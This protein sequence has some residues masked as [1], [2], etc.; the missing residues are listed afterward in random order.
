MGRPNEAITRVEQGLQVDPLSL[1]AIT[2]VAWELYFARRYDEAITQARKV[3]EMDPSYFPA[4][5]CLGLTYEQKRDFAAAIAELEKAA[6][7]C[8]VKCYG[9]IGPVSALSGDKAAAYQALKELQ[10][11][12]YVSPWLVAIVV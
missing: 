1:A 10:R 2:D 4:H 5:V 11:R 6:G 7:F 9:L 3:E 12:P 8:Q